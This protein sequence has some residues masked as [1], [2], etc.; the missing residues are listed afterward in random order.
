MR[1]SLIHVFTVGSP[2]AHLPMEIV[3][4]HQRSHISRIVNV[5]IRA[6]TIND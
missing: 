3:T 6:S 4:Y 5:Y 1:W 2:T